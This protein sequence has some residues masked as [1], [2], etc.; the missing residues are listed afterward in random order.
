MQN[1]KYFSETYF[2]LRVSPAAGESVTEPETEPSI[3][4][5]T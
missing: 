1:Q 4:N 2:L 5:K 3:F